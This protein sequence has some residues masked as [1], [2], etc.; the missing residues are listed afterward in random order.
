MV[1]FVLV[2][3]SWV[4]SVVWRQWLQGCARQGMKYT[5]RR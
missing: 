4:G 3:G 5:L 1:T 2:H